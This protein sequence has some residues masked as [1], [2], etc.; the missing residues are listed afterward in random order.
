MLLEITSPFD[1]RRQQ[2][3]L[4]TNKASN[5][6]EPNVAELRVGEDFDGKNKRLKRP[7]SPH[8]SIHKLQNNMILS[9]AHRFTGIILCG[10]PIGLATGKVTYSLIIYVFDFSC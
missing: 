5:L 2:K 10:L 1:I 3:Y 7:L 4:F 9:M 6:P 8:L